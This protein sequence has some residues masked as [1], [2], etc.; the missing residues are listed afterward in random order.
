LR[1]LGYRARIKRVSDD[2]YYNPATGPLEPG[3]HV[4]TGLFSWFADYPAA[5]N[6]FGTFFSCRAPSNWSKFCDRSIEAELRRALRLQ[7]TD[8]YL[9][10]RLWARIDREIVDQAPVV[11]LFTLKAV[12]VVSRR[13][14]NYQF[15]PQWGALLGQLWVR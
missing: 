4:Q 14:G 1:N 10:N 12:D 13:V 8:P 7:T 11:P 5:S 3:R 15:H 9:A 6:Y 2:V